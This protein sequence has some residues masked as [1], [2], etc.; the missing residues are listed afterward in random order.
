MPDLQFVYKTINSVV[1][2]VSVAD[3]MSGS[4]PLPFLNKPVWRDC[5]DLRRA[6]AHLKHGTRSSR[7][8]R[9]LKHL[10][11]YLGVAT[12]D[13]QGLIV[14]MKEDPIASRR[15]LIVVPNKLLPSIATAIHLYTKHSSKH[16]LKLVFNRHLFGLNSDAIINQV[17]DQCSQSNALKSVPKE[18][19]DK[20]SSLA[21]N[22]QGK[23][24]FTGILRRNRLKIC[25][26]RDVH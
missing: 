14:V 8:A 17:V 25:V 13:E 3:V 6:F 7:K 24:F 15:S 1:S 9:N 23:V 19:F 10:Q 16:Q 21:S 11:R 18:L 22:S 20:S 4:V 12:L 2:S 26:T 5:P